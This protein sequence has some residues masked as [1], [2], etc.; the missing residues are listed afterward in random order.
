MAGTRGD[1]VHTRDESQGESRD[2]AR[3]P[4]STVGLMI[5]RLLSLGG[6]LGSSSSSSSTSSSSSEIS[7][8]RRER[9]SFVLLSLCSVCVSYT[10]TTLPFCCSGKRL[11]ATRLSLA[12]EKSICVSKIRFYNAMDCELVPC[13]SFPGFS[14]TRIL[15]PKCQARSAPLDRQRKNELP[16]ERRRRGGR[17][18]TGESGHPGISILCMVAALSTPALTWSEKRAGYKRSSKGGALYYEG[19]LT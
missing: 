11:N 18:V 17:D 12:R 13:L 14:F 5:D 4:G 1:D 9:R 8:R 3:W 10:P 16:R 6:A 7:R 19:L 15:W 2:Y